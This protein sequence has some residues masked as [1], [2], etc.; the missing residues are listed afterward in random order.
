M[1]LVVLPIIAFANANTSETSLVE[2]PTQI[3]SQCYYE[4]CPGDPLRG[5]EGPAGICRL[6]F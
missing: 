3:T 2:M 1:A 5:P 6:H 4:N